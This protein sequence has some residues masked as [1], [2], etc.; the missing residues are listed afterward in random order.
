VYFMS[1][2]PGT[3]GPDLFR[4]AADRASAAEQLWTRDGGEV[5]LTSISSDG[6]WLVVG[7]RN[8]DTG[9]DISLASLGADSTPVSEYL[10]AGAEGSISPNGRW[11]AYYSGDLGSNQVF[12]RGFPEPVGQWRISEGDGNA[13]D[14][15]WAPDGS[16][17]YYVSLPNLMK[18][19]VSTEG[20]LSPGPPTVVVP[21][22]YSTGGADDVG[23]D[24][25][26]DGDRFL[27]VHSGA[28]QFGDTYIVTN[29][30]T[31]LRERMGGN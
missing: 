20:T 12:V 14:P 3:E 25:H 23:Y 5:T 11:M 1:T 27:V 10:R 9:R 17:L 13:Y 21:W 18:V 22:P 16:A 2:R 6:S 7:E 19:D 31:E 8:A 24:I 15:V 28:D 26:P 29:W 30:F 4:K